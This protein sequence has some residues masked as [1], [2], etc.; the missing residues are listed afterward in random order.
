MSMDAELIWSKSSYSGSA[1]DDCVEWARDTSTVY[2]RDSK[3]VAVP[4]VEMSRGAWSAFVAHAVR[5]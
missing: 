5:G 3:D 1:G 4:H 2:V